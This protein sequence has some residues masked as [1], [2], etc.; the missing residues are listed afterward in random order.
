MP[1][2]VQ[3]AISAGYSP[4]QIADEVGK[5]AGFDTAG[6]RKSGFS[7]QQII[8]ELASKSSPTGNS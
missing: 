5:A 1:F 2:D 3:G 8:Q 4:S 6:A 7:D